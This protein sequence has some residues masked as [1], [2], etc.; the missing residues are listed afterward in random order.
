MTRQQQGALGA[1]LFPFDI[2]TQSNEKF[3]SGHPRNQ[4]FTPIQ[5][6]PCLLD[7]P[8]HPCQNGVPGNLAISGVDRIILAD[9]YK[10]A[11]R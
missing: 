3:G 5:I 8:R 9:A 6:M 4:V 7:T 2:G 1:P 10:Q 11:D